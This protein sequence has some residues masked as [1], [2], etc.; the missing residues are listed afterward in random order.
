MKDVNIN[1][2]DIMNECK[3]NSN[4]LNLLL[5][6]KFFTQEEICEVIKIKNKTNTFR[7]K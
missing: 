1:R 4:L 6:D 3:N 7:K 5:K 2:T